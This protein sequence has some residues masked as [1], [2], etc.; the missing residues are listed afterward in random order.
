MSLRTGSEQRYQE[1]L[2]A[3]SARFHLVQ[4]AR[5]S[6]QAPALRLHLSPDQSSLNSVSYPNPSECSDLHYQVLFHL[7]AGADL[8]SC[9]EM[10]WKMGVNFVLRSFLGPGPA[11]HVVRIT[12]TSRLHLNHCS[13]SEVWQPGCCR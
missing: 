11:L 9:A 5:V 8:V 3:F 10:S 12:L 4:Y 6:C 2:T 7:H 13:N 1:S